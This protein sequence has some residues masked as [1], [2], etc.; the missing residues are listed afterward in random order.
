MQKF[1]ECFLGKHK[2]AIA[3]VPSRC[4][5]VSFNLSSKDAALVAAYID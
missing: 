3:H 4:S 5:N 2:N 1:Y